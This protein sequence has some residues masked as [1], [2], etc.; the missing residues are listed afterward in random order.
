LGRRPDDHRYTTDYGVFLRNCLASWCAKKQSVVSRSST[1]AEYR[2][3]AM[4]IAEVY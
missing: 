4:T 2:A 3:L 1:K